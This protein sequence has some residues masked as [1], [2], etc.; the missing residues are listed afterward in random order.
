MW[1]RWKCE[2]E[3]QQMYFLPVFRLHNDS[4]TLRIGP[5]SVSVITSVC[6]CPLWWTNELQW[7]LSQKVVYGDEWGNWKGWSSLI[8]LIFVKLEI[9]I[10]ISNLDYYLNHSIG[11]M[12]IKHFDFTETYL[13]YCCFII[14]IKRRRRRIR[15]RKLIMRRMIW[16]YSDL[17]KILK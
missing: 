10:I 5:G 2:V 4:F 8:F 3:T 7:L 6:H 1:F 15:V 17:K 12:C 16:I 11:M 13:F 14:I 9:I